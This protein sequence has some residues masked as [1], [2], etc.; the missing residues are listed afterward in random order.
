MLRMRIARVSHRSN[1]RTDMHDRRRHLFVIKQTTGA[2]L[3]CV[4]VSRD[5]DRMTGEQLA[6]GVTP[7]VS[8]GGSSRGVIEGDAIPSR[9]RR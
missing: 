1:L 3:V 8:S 2:T 4:S 9:E 6:G 5:A 7:R